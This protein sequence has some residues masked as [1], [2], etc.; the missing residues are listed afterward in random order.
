MAE[1]FPSGPHGLLIPVAGGE[2]LETGI[3]MGF[4]LH[5]TVML[6]FCCLILVPMLCPSA[7]RAENFK[8]T[9]NNHKLYRYHHVRD[10]HS[11][12]ETMIKDIK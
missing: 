4:L 1:V 5:Q 6:K 9:L 2:R 12:P 10:I 11:V 7:R 8:C 3:S